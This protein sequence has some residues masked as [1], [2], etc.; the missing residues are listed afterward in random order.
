LGIFLSFQIAVDLVLALFIF[1]IDIVVLQYENYELVVGL[2]LVCS[3]LLMIV[4]GEIAKK[5]GKAFPLYIGIPVWMLSTLVF[6]WLDSSV[7]V[8]VLCILAAL[9]AVGSSAGNLSTW[10]MLTDIFDIDEIRTGKR[11]EGIYSGMTTF[12]RKFASG[13]AILLMGFGF[14]ALGF[15]QNEYSVLKASMGD[16]DPSVYAQ[17]SVVSGIKWMFVIIPFVLLGIC[18]FFAI[19]NRIN[20]QRFDAVL[21]GIEEFKARGSIEGLTEQETKD[22]V[23]ATGL[24]TNKLWGVQ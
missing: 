5:K 7:S 8:I 17:S 1:Y 19:K 15:D 20:K 2:L 3:M 14:R 24:E 4:M 23:I 11:R 10:S 18:L 9:I 13:V 21:K 6:I 22:I 16:F 12:L